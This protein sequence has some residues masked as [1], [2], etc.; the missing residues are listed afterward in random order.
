MYVFFFLLL[1]L[2]TILVNK[3]V[4]INVRYSPG[5]GD[6]ATDRRSSE[7]TVPPPRTDVIIHSAVHSSV[8]IQ[9]LSATVNLPTAGRVCHEVWRNVQRHF[10]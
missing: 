5:V 1:R 10:G 3:D 8:I 7:Y 9:M 4:Y 6:L 2:T